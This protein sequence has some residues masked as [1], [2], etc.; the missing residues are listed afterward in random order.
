MT[1]VT[2][3]VGAYDDAMVGLEPGADPATVI[4]AIEEAVEDDRDAIIN[5]FV[6]DLLAVPDALPE[7]SDGEALALLA[8][9]GHL[10]KRPFVIGEALTCVGFREAAWR[11]ALA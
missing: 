1:D 6:G 4:A 10:V 7:L 2:G 9:D 11:D 5:Q 8:A 3:R